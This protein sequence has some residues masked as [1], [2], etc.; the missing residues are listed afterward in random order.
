MKEGFDADNVVRMEDFRKRRDGQ[1][2]PPETINESAVSS[3]ADAAPEVEKHLTLNEALIVAQDVVKRY[4]KEGSLFNAYLEGRGKNSSSEM[5][6]EF[7][8]V[9][10]IQKG[11]AKEHSIEYI[12]D[13]LEG[14][15]KRPENLSAVYVFCAAQEFIKRMPKQVA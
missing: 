2:M 5:I 13:S 3:H 8:A 12:R 7:Q 11:V 9:F 4:E 6:T 14:Y 10:N 15:T 1:S